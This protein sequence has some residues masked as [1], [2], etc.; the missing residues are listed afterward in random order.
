MRVVRAFSVAAVVLIGCAPKPAPSSEPEPELPQVVPADGTDDPLADVDAAPAAGA[1]EGPGGYDACQSFSTPELIVVEATVSAIGEAV[2][3]EGCERNIATPV[4]VTVH[5][6]VEG[7][8]G[9]AASITVW[10]EGGEVVRADGSRASAFAR[11]HCRELPKPGERTK[12]CLQR[13]GP[14]FV[15]R[16]C[17]GEG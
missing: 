12:L 1:V 14:D 13:A 7:D 4:T 2:E 10:L 15:P 17:P 11:G 3:F 6:V 9:G 5:D 8:A 16:C